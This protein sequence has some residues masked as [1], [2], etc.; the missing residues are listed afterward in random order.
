M[1]W[2]MSST[3][4]FM[5]C[6]SYDFNY[7]RIKLQKFVGGKK[8]EVYDIDS[9]LKMQMRVGI[10]VTSDDNDILRKDRKAV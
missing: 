8:E 9:A 4:I 6:V 3:R 5:L 1:K 2:L 7:R 10:L